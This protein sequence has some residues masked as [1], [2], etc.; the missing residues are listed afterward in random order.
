MLKSSAEF[1]SLISHQ[2]PRNDIHSLDVESLFTNVPVDRTINI[3]I[4]K[5]YN[6]P[7]I[8]PPPMK[9]STLRNLLKVCT[10]EVPFRDIDQQI[11]V[12]C[13][14]VGMGSPLSVTF[15]NFF[16]A[17]VENQ[18]LNNLENKPAM[19]VRYI[20]DIFVSCDENVLELLKKE[21]E[22]ISGLHFTVENSIDR[23]IP[24]L[25]V[26]VENTAERFKTTVYRK[27]TDIGACMN[28]SGD[29]PDQYK[30]SVIKGFLHRARTLSTDKTDMLIEIKRAKQILVNNGYSNNEVDT[31]VKRFLQ[32]NTKTD[33][34]SKVTH[35]IF[36]RNF[37]NSNY[38]KDEKALRDILRDN[39]KTKSDD[40]QI[41]LMIYYKTSKTTNLF[42]KNNL[43]PKVRDLASTHVVYEYNCQIDACKHLS[44]EATYD[45]VTTCTLS[46][47]LSNHL[48][49]GAIKQHC[50]DAHN[51]MITRK[52][53]EGSIR[54]RYKERDTN[55]LKILESLIILQEDPV[56]NKQDTGNTRTLK[57]YG[58]SMSR[59]I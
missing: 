17:E 53:I 47:R 52:E 8:T 2:T 42:M 4:N 31:E 56:I 11:Y 18:A 10:T 30:A 39:I 37:M 29:V 27:P 33:S 19:Y 21:L 16:M 55:R 58:T 7:S 57:L 46:R 20:D 54:I 59:D 49:K 1:V 24:F 15:A 44:K 25:N 34:S 6:H 41:K 48:Q 14:G 23:K 36:Y 51:K 45:G 50:L 3:I 5:V 32:N 12:Q 28:A 26:L 13:D 38:K 22:L 40:H 35:K 43:G 9:K